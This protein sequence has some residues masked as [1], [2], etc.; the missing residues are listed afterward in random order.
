MSHIIKWLGLVLMFVFAGIGISVGGLC[1][2]G[3]GGDS[4]SRGGCGYSIWGILALQDVSAMSIALV[5]Y[6]QVPVGFS[7]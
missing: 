4:Y 6:M 3:C 7:L 5:F 2:V 1:A